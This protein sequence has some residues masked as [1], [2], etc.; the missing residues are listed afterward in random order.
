M[1]SSHI[2]LKERGD[3]G[4]SYVYNDTLKLSANNFD[5]Y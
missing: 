1:C 2:K 3:G 5:Y 4:N